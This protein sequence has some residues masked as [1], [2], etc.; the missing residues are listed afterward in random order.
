[1]FRT[2]KKLAKSFR[3]AWAPTRPALTLVAVNPAPTV[4]VDDTRQEFVATLKAVCDQKARAEEESAQ[5]VV[6]QLW[7]H[8]DRYAEGEFAADLFY[9]ALHKLGISSADDFDFD[10]LNAFGAA[11]E[12]YQEKLAPVE[13]TLADAVREA[14]VTVEYCDYTCLP[15]AYD[16]DTLGVEVVKQR[17]G[18]RDIPEWLEEYINY[19]RLGDDYLNDKGGMFTSYGFFA[20][21]SDW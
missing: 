11:I 12:Y 17:T 4:T 1:M 14:A 20:K 13:V 7:R 2:V 21:G 10:Q 8:V 6:T 19:E 3:K 16:E 5:T 9:D 15:Y 18:R